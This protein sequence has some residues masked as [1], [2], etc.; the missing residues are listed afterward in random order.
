MIHSKGIA[1]SFDPGQAVF[2]SIKVSGIPD[3][4]GG[5]ENL[6]DPSARYLGFNVQTFVLNQG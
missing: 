2:M 6:S 3:P 4:D 1:V 5:T